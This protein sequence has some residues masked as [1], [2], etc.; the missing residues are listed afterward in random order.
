MIYIIDHQDSFTWNVFHQFSEFD[1][2]ICSNYFEINYEKLNKADTIVLSP[3]PGSPKDYPTTSKIYKKFKG[4]KKIIGICLG[5]QQ[6]LYN[7]SGKIVQQ[8][9]IYH[10]YQSKIRVTNNSNIFTRGKIFEVGRYHSLKL[11]EPFSSKNIKITMRCVETK[12]PMAIENIK[13]N[14][15][16]FQFHPESFLTKNGK[17][18]I[19]KILSA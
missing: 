9:N 10:G 6:I 13:E 4:K 15:F 1:K 17:N 7:E 5:F 8:K 3:G 11:Q 19:K 18:I 14:V 12:T 2:V 16:G